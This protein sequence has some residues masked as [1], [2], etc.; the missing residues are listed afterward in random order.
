MDLRSIICYCYPFILSFIVLI[1]HLESSRQ[2][3]S[4]DVTDNRRGVYGFEHGCIVLRCRLPNQNEP[5]TISKAGTVFVQDL[6]KKRPV[7]RF[8]YNY[9][10]NNTANQTVHEFKISNISTDDIGTWSFIYNEYIARSIKMNVFIRP[11]QEEPTCDTVNKFPV[12]ITNDLL[13]MN[14][15]VQ[16]SD[17]PVTLE[18]DGLCNIT[19][20]SLEAKTHH[21]VTYSP[22]SGLSPYS[23]LCQ[24]GPIKIQKE[25]TVSLNL[26]SPIIKGNPIG[27]ECVSNVPDAIITWDLP[28]VDLKQSSSEPGRSS[29]NV[30]LPANYAHN[31]LNISCY[32]YYRQREIS[33]NFVDEISTKKNPNVNA[34][35]RFVSCVYLL[36][37]FPLLVQSL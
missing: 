2:C 9:K 33:A 3:Q 31:T 23:K 1:G 16:M 24:W 6:E 26:L 10:N 36:I 30:T 8:H 18:L 13:E 28:F 29:V 11:S 19:D 34:S 22:K 5:V 32:A 15:S 12:Y 37:A 35:Q 25:L 27:F 14:C 4:E 7:P 17:P 21:R 20:F